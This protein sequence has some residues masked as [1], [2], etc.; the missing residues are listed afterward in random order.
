MDSTTGRPAARFVYDEKGVNGK[1]RRRR[2]RRRR[3]RRHFFEFLLWHHD[4]SPPSVRPSVR[5]STISKRHDEQVNGWGGRLRTESAT[6]PKND[7]RRE[8]RRGE[9]GEKTK[10]EEL[11]GN[12]SGAK[13]PPSSLPSFRPAFVYSLATAEAAAATAIS[14]TAAVGRRETDRR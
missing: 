9:E 3:R 2:L 14:A 12:G 10:E 5:P 8:E 11:R 1:R 4:F 13:T 6:Q 7:G